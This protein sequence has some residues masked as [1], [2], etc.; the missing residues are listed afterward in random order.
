VTGLPGLAPTGAEVEAAEMKAAALVFVSPAMAAA[1]THMERAYVELAA[2]CQSWGSWADEVAHAEEKN[3]GL[4]IEA[5]G[6]A[7]GDSPLY[8][9]ALALGSPYIE[10]RGAVADELCRIHPPYSE[11][12]AAGRLLAGV[13]AHLAERAGGG[14]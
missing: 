1:R 7:E 2:A 14:S 11:I 13:S 10:A 5:G 6:L 9:A 3:V 12:R 4:G 8:D